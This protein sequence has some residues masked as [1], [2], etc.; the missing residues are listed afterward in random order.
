MSTLTNDVRYGFRQLSKSPGFTAVAVL[1]LALAIG[2]NT[3]I[4]SLINSMLL[5]SLPVPNAE[6]L[7]CVNWIG[8]GM[9]NVMTSGRTENAPSG[10]TR[11][12]AFSCG[13]YRQFRDHA[14]AGAEAETD[15]VEFVALSLLPRLSIVAKGTAR[16]ADGLMVSGNFFDGLGVKPFLGRTF[17]APGNQDSAASAVV[18]SYAGWQKHFNGDP[19]VLGQALLLNGHSYTVIGVLGRE[20]LGVLSHSHTD[21]YVTLAAQPQLRPDAS[22]EASDIWATQIMA[23]IGAGTNTQQV[24]ATLDVLFGAAAAPHLANP[25]AQPPHIILTD[26]R[27]GL[28]LAR[29]EHTRP[30]LVLMAI[31]AI[32]LVVACI[33]LAGLLLARGTARQQE[34][35]VRSALG[36]S[37][38]HLLRQSLIESLLIVLAGAGLGAVLATWG[39][40]GLAGLL[41]PANMPLDT[42]GDLRVFA[43]TLGVSVLAVAIFGLIP[44]LRAMHTDPMGSLKD[45]SSLGAPRL[46]LG[47]VLVTAQVGLCLLLLVGAGLFARTLINLRRIETGF[48]T[49]NLLT[50]QINAGQA[51]YEGQRLM[52]FC[53]QLGQRI[54]ALP[55]VRRVARSNLQLLTGWRNET[56][57]TVSGQSDRQHILQLNVSDSFLSTMGI[58]LQAGRNFGVEDQAESTKVIVVNQTLART[59]FPDEDPIGHSVT[60]NRDD[61]RI[62]G[63]CGDTKYYDL[64]VP[65]KP[66]VLFADRQHAGHMGSV[67]YYVRT[68]T[69]PMSLVPTIRRTLANLAPL[70]PMAEI[71]TQA[72]Q[73]N[74]SIAQ[75]RLFAALGSALACLAVLLAC[76]GLYGL[77][78]YSVTR[79]RNEF[80]IRLALGAT[81]HTVAWPV[82]RDAL[83]LSMLG[84]ALGL[85]VA[86][87]L[88]RVTRSLIYGVTPHD[89]INLALAAGALVVVA[90][91]AAWLPARRA[92]KIDPME[93]LRYE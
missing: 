71:K 33:N 29:D 68:A 60:I 69:E 2:A 76:I 26:G 89:P 59:V 3:A 35:A 47:R 54:A 80:G 23:R 43:F 5:R 46:R 61:Y 40:T 39:K 50:F 16:A 62:V 72:L 92:A 51:G 9:L 34:L 24:Q 19:E 18:L 63:V 25:E 74:E 77:L 27:R 7:Y 44:A 73:L 66:T 64:K 10:G 57:M 30:L 12:D 84:I 67:Y 53:E 8:E 4:F 37:R 38:W 21:A 52:D 28:A 13:M 82:L 6:E 58:P 36:A 45:R 22:L 48:D 78:A 65:V 56:M 17:S 42:S 14:F 87:A 79:R 93:A 41:L 11:S 81:P 15:G 20:F 55:G 49:E 83:L 91:T 1:S 90:V 75:E 85:P 88:V 70:I 86:W 31:V 32:V